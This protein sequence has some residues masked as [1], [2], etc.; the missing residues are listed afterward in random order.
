MNLIPGLIAD[1]DLS[2]SQFEAM[3]MKGTGEPFEVA[4]VSATTDL[5]IGILQ[6]DPNVAGQ[7]AEVAGPGGV[8]KAKCGGTIVAGDLLV[9]ANDGELV[10]SAAF[11]VDATHVHTIFAIA[12]ALEDGADQEIIKVLVISP[13]RVAVS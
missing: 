1:A 4:V 5:P 6:N 7:A 8:A 13:T 2:A 10:A 3:K 12:I 9:V 11:D